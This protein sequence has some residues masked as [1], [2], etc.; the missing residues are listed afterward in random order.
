VIIDH[1]YVQCMC[2]VQLLYFILMFMLFKTSLYNF[3]SE[4]IYY[5]NISA[6]SIMS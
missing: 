1:V 5:L 2:Y 6:K 4:V 3:N